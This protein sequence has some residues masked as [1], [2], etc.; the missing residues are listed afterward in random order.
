MT[1][2][3]VP[4]VLL[5]HGFLA[6]PSLMR[7]MQRRLERLGYTV[8][9]AELSSL[10]LQDMNLL[11]EQVGASIRMVLQQER[12]DQ[13][14]LVG[15]SLGGL[16]AVRYLQKHAPLGQVARVVAI[17][18][19]FQGAWAAAVGLPLFGLFSKSIWQALPSSDLLEEVQSAGIPDGVAVTSICMAGDPI[20][21][22]KRCRLAGA[23][24]VVVRGFPSL[25][26][27]QWLVVSKAALKETT[28]AL[29]R[30]SICI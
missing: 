6:G 13:I 21:P 4:P 16:L 22:P 7:P 30:H 1:K 5:I 15:V 3:S 29:E 10:A 8:H 20:A 17:G 26:T 11:T 28:K 9:V 2:K 14:D 25:V 23:R 24:H 27:H 18:T 19:P 12:A